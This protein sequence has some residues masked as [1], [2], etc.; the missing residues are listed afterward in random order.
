MRDEITS[1]PSDDVLAEQK[2]SSIQY[3]T[4]SKLVG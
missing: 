1:M 4:A 3:S 2:V